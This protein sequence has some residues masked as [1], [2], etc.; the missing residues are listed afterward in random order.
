MLVGSHYARSYSSSGQ[1]YWLTTVVTEIV[2]ERDGYV[3]FATA[4]SLYEFTYPKGK[5]DENGKVAEV[6]QA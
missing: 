3:K 5:K 2:E 1:D 4:K 6:L